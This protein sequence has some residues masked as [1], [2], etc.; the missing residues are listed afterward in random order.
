MYSYRAARSARNSKGPGGQ[1]NELQLRPPRGHAC[2]ACGTQAWAAACFLRQVV[3][4]CRGLCAHTPARSPQVVG[5]RSRGGLSAPR[6]ESSVR[7]CFKPRSALRGHATAPMQAKFTDRSRF[8]LYR[9]R[10]PGLCRLF[11]LP[12]FSLTPSAEAF[13]FS[14]PLHS[15]A[16]PMRTH[17]PSPHLVARRLQCACWCFSCQP[18]ELG[19]RSRTE[20]PDWRQKRAA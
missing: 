6:A 13:L 1:E 10:L 7:T 5:G 4:A 15:P 18:G 19:R 8:L 17:S 9:F 3:R 20:R 11:L 16:A 14:F 12:S 2:M